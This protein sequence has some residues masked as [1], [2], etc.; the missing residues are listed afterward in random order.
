M[1]RLLVFPVRHH[2]PAAA[3]A[4]R[5]T[6]GA[7]KP[8]R[9]L[10]E[11]PSDYEGRMAELSLGHRLPLAIYSYA[12]GPEGLRAGAWYPFC[13]NSPEW[14]AV[15]EAAD[16]GIPCSFMDLP[17]YAMQALASALPCEPQAEQRWADGKLRRGAYVDMLCAQT[18][19][20]GFD[21]LW[22]DL[23]EVDSSLSAEEFIKRCGIFCS[24]SRALDKPD[25]E[26]QAREAFMASRI[27]SALDETQGT[28]IAVCGGYHAQALE[29][30]VAEGDFSAPGLHDA[31]AA[32]ENFQER[33]ISLT[34][35]SDARMDSLR[36]YD[37]GMPGPAFYREVHAQ[38]SAQES[39]DSDGVLQAVAAALRAR[40]V[41]FSSADLIATRSTSR[42]LADIRGHG[43]VWRRDIL[44]GVRAAV[45][46]EDLAEGGRHPVLEAV[47]EVLRGNRVGAL[48]AGTA[49]PPLVADAR[50][51]LE[52]FSL[53]PA[54]EPRKVSLSL[55]DSIQR[56]ASRALHKLSILGI[57][58]FVLEEGT[59]MLARRDLSDPRETWRIA[60]LAEFDS[61]L[62]E[63]A[64]YGPTL[65]EAAARALAEKAGKIE[66]SA[67][68]A[69]AILVEAAL[70]GIGALLSPY[71]ARLGSL[72]RQA[73]SFADSSG[74][75]AHL[76]YLQRYDSILDLGEP[77]LLASL[78][79]EAWRL[80]LYLLEASAS[81]PGT[82][83][84]VIRGMRS[85]L[86]CAES[87]AESCG[88][89]S[90]GQEFLAVLS[91]VMADP[92]TAAL[93]RG[94]ALGT[95]CRLSAADSETVTSQVKSLC[96]LQSL[97]DFLAGLFSLAREAVQRD[98]AVVAALDGA[99]CGMDENLFLAALP[100]LRFAFS[101]FTPRE[102]RLFVESLAG[103]GKVGRSAEGVAFAQ[104]TAMPLSDPESLARA[105]AYEA[106]LF[107][108]AS[109]HGLG[110]AID[111]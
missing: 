11:G 10:V 55:R 109:R 99:I 61:G 80:S 14:V 37:A 89:G 73:G 72:L 38:R 39:F 98:A 58:G 75:L 46:K 106:A 57:A 12:A 87:C 13:E 67:T 103:I 8:S 49:L 111:G 88:D 19:A 44:D 40:G 31:L 56:E 79:A 6:I 30:R 18:G 83:D 74:A 68:A 21:D 20:D 4:L 82:D 102:K 17:L 105:M 90:E 29:R 93:T 50:G 22:D 35:Y 15:R 71:A 100:A 51:I 63:A 3:K 70:S 85:L 84:Q 60:W 16:L 101:W 45:V 43:D 52:S 1:E 54:P 64:R 41:P 23:F 94:A 97:G 69:A 92:A 48:A 34:P 32:S 2:S 53:L 78:I 9:I 77:E 110:E 27:A 59:D 42:A 76:L 96:G 65:A 62:I 36:G 25:P 104:L 24:Q 107:A 91:R 7:R 108:E 66:G 47:A 26:D 86:A 95:L 81:S 28:V 33:G 5:E